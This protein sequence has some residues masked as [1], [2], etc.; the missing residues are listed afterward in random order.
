MA[1]PL[2]PAMLRER[3]TLRAAAVVAI[4]DAIPARPIRG[5]RAGGHRSH[6][7]RP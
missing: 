1:L 3:R 7:A 2:L 5:P 4:D 6:H